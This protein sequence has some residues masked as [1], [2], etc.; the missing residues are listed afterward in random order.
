[1]R[2]KDKVTVITGAATGIGLACAERFCAEGAKVILSDINDVKGEAEA[3]RLKAKGYQAEFAY[4]DVSVKSDVQALV[5]ATVAHWGRLDCVIAN[6]GIVHVTGFLDLEEEDFDRV[7]QTNLKGVFLTG[8]LAARQMVKQG[9]GG[10]IVNM[11]SVN[12]I[13]AIPKIAPYVTSKGGVNQLTKAMSLELVEHGIRVN[14]IGPGSISTEM[15]TKVL[16]DESAR[17]KV[18]SRTPMGRLGEPDEVAKV[19][20]FL[21][22]DD[23]SYV[24]GQVVYIDGG[25]LGLNYTVPV[26][27]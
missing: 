25:R 6:A 19:A 17:K 9:D 23:S 27:D 21:A 5:D 2:L 12:G 3:Q 24:T 26:A 10:T 4:C 15:V 1:M 20:L 16:V 8:Q 7:L 11:S 22:S 13:M 14:A 18:L